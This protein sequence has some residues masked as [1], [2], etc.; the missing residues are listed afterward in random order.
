MAYCDGAVKYE[1]DER[2]TADAKVEV[3]DVVGNQRK[4]CP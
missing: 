1:T 2:K 3:V 4:R